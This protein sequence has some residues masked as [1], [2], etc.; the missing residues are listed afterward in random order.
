V[1]YEE[2]SDKVEQGLRPILLRL[3]ENG[4]IDFR[5]KANPGDANTPWPVL[6]RG[7]LSAQED[8]IRR[9]HLITTEVID[10]FQA[11]RDVEIYLS[12]LPFSSSGVTSSRYLHFQLE[13]FFNEMYILHQRMKAFTTKLAREFKRDPGAASI[14]ARLQPVVRAVE[15][16]F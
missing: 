8:Y 5:L 14:Q 3:L 1:G 10:S 9:L 15:R 2:F 12:R 11:M 13:S 6:I 7:H 4:E 16:L